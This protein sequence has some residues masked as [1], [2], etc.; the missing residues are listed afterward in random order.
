MIAFISYRRDDYP[1]AA[2]FLEAELEQAFGIESVF[3]DTERLRAGDN[4]PQQLDKGLQEAS[5]LL[6][7]IGPSWLKLADDYG[8]RRLDKEGDWVRREIETSLQRKIMVIP[9]LVGRASIPPKDG[10]PSSIATFTDQQALPLRETH[11][12]EDLSPLIERLESIGFKRTGF[13]YVFPKP[14]DQVPRSLSETEIKENLTRIPEWKI[15]TSPLPGQ[16]PKVRT[17][18]MRIFTFS[19]FPKAIQFMSQALEH[20]EV[21][22]HHPRWENLWKTVTVWLTT[23]DI[24][25]VPSKVDF[26]LAEYLDKLYLIYNPLDKVKSS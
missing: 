7:V 23:W 13:Q 26:E 12:T 15:V 22:K 18:L 14:P 6:V 5:A 19:N 4:W 24:G 21:L 20:V 2:R 17:E 16:H 25:H 10:L 8:R 11:W 9:V 1:I 3:M